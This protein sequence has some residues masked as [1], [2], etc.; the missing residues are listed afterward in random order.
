LCYHYTIEKQ[1][2]GKGE[3][4]THGAFRHDSF[5][6]CCFKPLSHSSEFW[7]WKQDSNPPPSDYKTDALPDELFQ[8]IWLCTLESNQAHSR[9][10]VGRSHHACS[11]TKNFGEGSW[12]GWLD[13]N[14]L[15]VEVTDLQSAVPHQLHR[16]PVAGMDQ[17]RQLL[18]DVDVDD[19]L[20]VCAEGIEPSTSCAQDTRATTALR[21]EVVGGI[22][23]RVF[24]MAWSIH[25]FCFLAGDAS[26]GSD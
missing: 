21:T 1:I 26:D 15:N 14:Q 13:S 17:Y 10:T 4:R 5:Q 12:W 6:D 22:R 23:S 7:C 2:G 19:E 20:L 3:I 25:P 24:M 11:Y 16:I 18:G 8:R 9:L